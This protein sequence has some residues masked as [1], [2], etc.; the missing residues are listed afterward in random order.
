MSLHRTNRVGEE[1]SKKQRG[2]THICMHFG[3]AKKKR[4]RELHFKYNNYIKPFILFFSSYFIYSLYINQI[5]VYAPK[6]KKL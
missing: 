5:I 1:I 3:K 4:R 2:Y 6:K